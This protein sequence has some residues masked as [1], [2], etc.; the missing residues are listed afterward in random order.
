MKK[1][2]LLILVCCC[3]IVGCEMYKTR[4]VFIENKSDTNVTLEVKN[5]KEGTAKILRTLMPLDAGKTLSLPMYNDGDISLLGVSRN[6]L[7]KTSSNYYEVLKMNSVKFTIYNKTD[8]SIAV[9]DLNNLFDL[10]TIAAN[11]D[12]PN[13]DIYN[14]EKIQPIAITSDG[15]NLVLKVLVS[16][17][18]KTIVVSY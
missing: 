8:F 15:T 6:Y 12:K 9:K 3:L 1:I 14:A 16:V 5:F 13:I 11:T 17:S 4:D 18:G 7:N 10:Q 2:V